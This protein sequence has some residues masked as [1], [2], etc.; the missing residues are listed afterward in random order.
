MAAQDVPFGAN[1][2]FG[3]AELLQV[4]SLRG[5]TGKLL[6]RSSAS[7]AELYF[8]QGRLVWGDLLPPTATLDLGALAPEAQAYAIH[9]DIQR[10]LVEV[11]SWPAGQAI[12]DADAP[13][14]PFRA[15]HDVDR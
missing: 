9:N 15:A 8:V 14:A 2:Q 3:V 10:A 11:L 1:E 13:P 5:R 6:L 4:L 12:F 7:Q